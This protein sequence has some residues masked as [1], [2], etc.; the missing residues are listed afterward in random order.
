MAG[1]RG[2]KWVEFE[3]TIIAR[4][5]FHGER[6]EILVEPEGAYDFRSGKS[7]ELPEILKGYMVFENAKKGKKA[8]PEKLEEVFGTSD[9]LKVAEEIL[10]RGE[11]QL[12]SEQ[13]SKMVEAKKKRIVTILA[14]NSINPQ[15]RLPH[16]PQRIERAIEEAK[17]P[18]DPFRNPEEQAKDIIRD[19]Q[20]I[21]PIRMEQ[22]ELEVRIPAIHS[23]KA[24]NAISR[25][26]SVSKEEWMRDGSW[27]GT[28]EV[29]A[30]L[31]NTFVDTLSKLTKGSAQIKRKT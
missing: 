29:S 12:T 1:I 21:L 23:G 10:R 16:P 22:I 17:V 13:R 4:F 18:I 24:Y 19:L 27:T 28:V 6:F 14:R 26:G 15:T 30:G 25:L 9:L 11:L 7:V 3:N 8:S 20:P 2:D 31:Y 5:E